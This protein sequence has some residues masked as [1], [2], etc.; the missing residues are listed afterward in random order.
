MSMNEL[1]DK[2]QEELKKRSDAFLNEYEALINKYQ[3]DF[4][5]IPHYIPQQDGNFVTRIETKLL[6]KKYW[7]VPSPIIV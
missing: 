6:D 2:Q 3:M 5:S 1:T 4:I 7:N